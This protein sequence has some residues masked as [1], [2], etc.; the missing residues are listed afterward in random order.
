MSAVRLKGVCSAWRELHLMLSGIRDKG[1]WMM[2]AF[3][4]R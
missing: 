1:W 2:R 4:L 3:A